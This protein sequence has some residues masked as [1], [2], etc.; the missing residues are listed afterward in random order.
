MLDVIWSNTAID[1]YSNNIDYLEKEWTQKVI[2]DFI[3]KTD[4][5]IKKIALENLRFKPTDYENIFQVPV[6]KQI[7]LFY[8]IDEYKVE[9]L[10]FWNN[11]Q[12]PNKLKLP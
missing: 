3:E 10:R 2:E 5:I 9:L 11:Y 1:D 7:T 4:D 8:K 6:V 12:N